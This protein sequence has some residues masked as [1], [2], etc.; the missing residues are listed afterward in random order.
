MNTMRQRYKN[1]HHFIFYTLNLA[2]IRCFRLTVIM[3]M[4]LAC[5]SGPAYP[6]EKITASIPILSE[7]NDP[8]KVESYYRNIIEAID[9]ALPDVEIKTHR[10][11]F[12]RSV[13]EVS[14]GVSD[15]H[16]PILCVPSPA[17]ERYLTFSNETV[18]T[19][20]FA[21]YSKK[22][23]PITL[24]QLKEATYEMTPKAISELSEKLSPSERQMLH[25]VTGKFPNRQ[26]YFSAVEEA[27]GR[28]LNGSEYTY[29]AQAGFP[30]YLETERFHI[31]MVD[32]PAYPATSITSSL[33]RLVSGRVDAIIYPVVQ[34]ESLVA[35]DKLEP[36]I[37]RAFFKHYDVCFLVAKNAHGEAINQ[38][39]SEGLRLIKER[40]L[41]DAIMLEGKEFE[42]EWL[43][44]Y[45]KTNKMPVKINR[46]NS[47]NP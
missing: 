23:A 26:R 22:D 35:R 2:G 41:F 13:R 39:V 9:D 25:K 21:I 1:K 19:V 42:E 24:S 37:A 43:R 29:F 45:S 40:G 46:N 31:E 14:Q 32:F 10:R 3:V 27:L 6:L 15:F 17:I 4:A 44:T 18:S 36:F 34:I 33:H 38:K 20:L 30:Y 8:I 47:D 16:L 7:P 5:L 11:P 28:P 12:S